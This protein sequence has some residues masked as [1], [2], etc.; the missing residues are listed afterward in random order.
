MPIFNVILVMKFLLLPFPKSL[1]KPP[2]LTVPTRSKVF[3]TNNFIPISKPVLAT[4][5][6]F[7]IVGSWNDFYSGLD[8]TC[9][10][11]PIIP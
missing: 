3:S 6:L 11:P 5:S 9:P 10:K 1:R 7:S 2:S 4:V 8:L